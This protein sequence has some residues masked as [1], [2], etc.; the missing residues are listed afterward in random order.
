[1]RQ[2]FPESSVC[3]DKDT[4][5]TQKINQNVGKVCMLKLLLKHRESPR[6]FHA[7]W[8]TKIC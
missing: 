3:F 1:M 5:G 2:V 7:D 8:L 4:E 6:R